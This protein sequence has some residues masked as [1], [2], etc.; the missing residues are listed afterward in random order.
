[1]GHGGP[2]VV[3]RQ[4]VLRLRTGQEA[5]DMRSKNVK[6]WY[7]DPEAMCGFSVRR[8]PVF[9]GAKCNGFPWSTRLS[10]P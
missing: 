7:C 10:E 9:C 3:P 1:M 8:S 4:V 6:N 5:F 2:F